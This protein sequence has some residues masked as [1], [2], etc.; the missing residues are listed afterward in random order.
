MVNDSEKGMPDDRL[1]LVNQEY[2]RLLDENQSAELD[3]EPV[4]PEELAEA[5]PTVDKILGK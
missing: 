2:A 4:S 1:G 3:S 5:Q